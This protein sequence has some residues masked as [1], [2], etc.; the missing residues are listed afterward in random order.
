M[1]NPNINRETL[2]SIG[3]TSKYIGVISYNLTLFGIACYQ[4]QLLVFVIFFSS[5]KKT[6]HK[7]AT[8]NYVFVSN[9]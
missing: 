3:Q 8:Q 4:P 5:K 2:T 9:V 1:S 6:R 7:H